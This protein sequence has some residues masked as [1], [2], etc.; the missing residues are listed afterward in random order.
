MKMFRTGVRTGCLAVFLLASSAS[1]FEYQQ[2]FK[3]HCVKCHGATTQKAELRL[4]RL[5][6][7]ATSESAELWSSVADMIESGDMPPDDEPPAADVKRLLSWI[8]GELEQASR[9]IPALR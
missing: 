3:Q 6:A 9:P 7:P 5:P 8:S 1:A 2:L 4:D